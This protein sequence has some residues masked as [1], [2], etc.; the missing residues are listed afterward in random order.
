MKLKIYP[1]MVIATITALA[2]IALAWLQVAIWLNSSKPEADMS[3]TRGNLT[4]KLS[5]QSPPPLPPTVSLTPQPTNSTEAFSPAP[6]SQA[7]PTPTAEVEASNTTASAQAGSQ[8]VLRVSN[9]TAHPVR[10]AI[11]ARHSDRKS[12]AKPAHW[13]FAPGE[14][15]RKGLLLSLPGTKLKLKPGDI[16]VV[17]AQDGSRRYWGPYVVGESA[18]P[19][20]N[21]KA[22][23]WQLVLEP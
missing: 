13:D 11:L 14:G 6:N 16:L 8:G 17:F 5:L 22:T 1:A 18:S 23:E 21:A 4:S 7:T 12:E 9:R 15:S 3:L 10:V 20:W 19:T 2:A